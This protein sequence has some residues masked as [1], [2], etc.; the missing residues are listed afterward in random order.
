[1]HRVDT[2]VSFYWFRATS[3]ALVIPHTHT[4]THAIQ[5]CQSVFI[6]TCYIKRVQM[7]KQKTARCP[8]SSLPCIVV[9][10]YSFCLVKDPPKAQYIYIYIWKIAIK[11]RPVENAF[12][13]IIFHVLRCLFYYSFFF[14][15]II[16]FL[17]YFKFL[18][19]TKSL[20]VII[21]LFNMAWKKCH[22]YTNKYTISYI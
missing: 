9:A 8:L 21:C 20:T 18:V 14:L 12:H 5:V 2:F 13:I 17:I 7:R 11:R 16:Y 4:G 6:H 10:I 15:R 19:Q 22:N 1:M 3:R